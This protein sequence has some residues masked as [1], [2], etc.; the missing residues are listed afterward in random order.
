VAGTLVPARLTNGAFYS[1]RPPR[2]R[3][4]RTKSTYN[5][6]AARRL[7][8]TIKL[9]DPYKNAASLTESRAND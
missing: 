8:T 2:V 1:K 7:I 3:I 6:I 4:H 5:S 9:F